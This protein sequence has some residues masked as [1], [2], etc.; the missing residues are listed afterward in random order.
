MTQLSDFRFV[1]VHVNHGR[2]ISGFA[3]ARDVG[4]EELKRALRA[5][6]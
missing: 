4:E 5:E 2:Q 6:A 1:A 3:A